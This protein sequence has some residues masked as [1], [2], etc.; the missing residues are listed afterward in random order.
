MVFPGRP[1]APEARHDRRRLVVAQLPGPRSGTSRTRRGTGRSGRIRRGLWP[2]NARS[3]G[4]D[5]TP[6]GRLVDV[7]A[8]VVGPV[9]HLWRRRALVEWARIPPQ[10][11][12]AKI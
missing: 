11:R 7:V 9:R 8:T 5:R 4:P 12:P 1:I 2:G 6:A 3:L 10:T